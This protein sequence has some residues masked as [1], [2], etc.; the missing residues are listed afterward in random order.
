MFL[1]RQ[2][3]ISLSHKLIKHY[4][5]T[6][7]PGGPVRH[8]LSAGIGPLPDSRPQILRS[9][10]VGGAVHPPQQ[11]LRPLPPPQPPRPLR[12]L[13]LQGSLVYYLGKKISCFFLLTNIFA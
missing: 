10:H 8:L 9:L 7:E 1:K 2:K 4:D 3:F 6:Q 12:R 11:P 13:L 5:V